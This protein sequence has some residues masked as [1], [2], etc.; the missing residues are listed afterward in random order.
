VTAAGSSALIDLGGGNT[1][2]LSG[3]L[4]TNTIA[5]LADDIVIG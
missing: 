4:A 3:Y 5:S 1:I 2:L